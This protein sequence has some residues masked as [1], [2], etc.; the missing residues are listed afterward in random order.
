MNQLIQELQ[1]IGDVLDQ[2]V[3]KAETASVCEPVQ[4]LEDS[5]YSIGRA[6]SGSWIGYQA[7]VYYDNLE[8]PPPGSHFSREWG[9]LM[10][11]AAGTC[12][13]WKEFDPVDV[14]IAVENLAGNPDISVALALAREAEVLFRDKRDQLLSVIRVFGTITD[15]PDAFLE[16]RVREAQA[17]KVSSPG[18]YLA[19]WTPSLIWSQDSLAMSQGTLTPPHIEI[20]S[21]VMW[22]HSAINV[23]KDLSRIT[24]KVIEHI[25]RIGQ[26]ELKTTME[27]TQV[28]IVHDRSTAWREL[29]DFIS[30]RL[31]LDYEE[32][33]CVPVPGKS[34]TERLSE[35]LDTACIALLVF[36]SEDEQTDRT[37]RARMNVIHETGLFQ[38]RLGFKRAIVLLEEGCETF[39]NIAELGQIHFP[40]GNINACF[41]DIR[42]TLAREGISS[43]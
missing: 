30:E 8:P 13:R 22:F 7:Y 33:N 29:R 9:Y 11:G 19:A 6:W 35:M 43:R 10:S 39:S 14:E 21:K 34:N 25:E 2:I 20:L 37:M 12:G 18:E 28:C 42:A 5:V 15:Q 31:K 3:V 32:F 38:G 36:T 17:L 24:A 26:S 23:I 16:E 4:H 27:G 1:N 41:E 40:K